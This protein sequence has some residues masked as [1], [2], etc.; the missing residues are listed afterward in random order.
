MN[1]TLAVDTIY[2]GPATC[3]PT[4]YVSVQV[5]GQTVT[6]Q[7]G[8]EYTWTGPGPNN[9]NFI[10][11]SV[12]TDLS[13]GWYYVTVQDAVCEV[14]DSAFVDIL[15]PPIAAFDATP[16]AGCSPLDV[17]MVN[18]SQNA[19]SFKWTFGNGNVLTVN[20]MDGQTQTYTEDA[21]I[22]LIAIEGSCAD[23]TFATISIN[24]CGCTDPIA[25]NYN[26][27]AEV[28]DGSCIPPTPTVEAPNVFSPNGDG[29]NDVFHL[30]TTN[31]LD[32]QLTITNR[33]G[34]IM[35]EGQGLNPEWNGKTDS[36]K[37]AEDG[38]YFYKY[39]LKGYQEA[40]LEGHGFLH[41][42]R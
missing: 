19:S 32:I 1:Q 2:V 37:D 5:T 25:I 22:E 26:P 17:T 23:T 15:N 35:F 41:L 31:A 39:I 30:I 10:N 13:S 7:Q 12:W 40:I 36:G 16:L 11:A 20:N 29:A 28:D 42:V 14:N 18:N 24:I 38:V 4:G 3:E 8:L 27:M 34:N 9:P 6:P 33:W 21:I